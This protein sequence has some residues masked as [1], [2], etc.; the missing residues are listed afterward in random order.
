MKKI[1]L[2]LDFA[3]L[4]SM[5][6]LLLVLFHF[7]FSRRVVFKP[8]T[9]QPTYAE[10]D[11][12]PCL[13]LSLSPFLIGEKGKEERQQ[14]DVKWSESW[15]SLSSFACLVRL[16]APGKIEHVFNFF[17]DQNL[18]FSFFKSS[19]STF[20][21][22]NAIFRMG[23]QENIE[24]AMKIA[25]WFFFLLHDFCHNSFFHEKKEILLDQHYEYCSEFLIGAFGK[26]TETL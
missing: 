7:S 25:Y 20:V 12:N 16:C 5:S 10:N 23:Q 14:Q 9:K 1:K 18:F 21:M 2:L 22:G 11:Q 3:A 26:L 6:L 15:T 4:P 17:F 19:S 8:E 24:I 13:C